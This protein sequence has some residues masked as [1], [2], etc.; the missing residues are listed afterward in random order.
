MVLSKHTDADG[1]LVRITRLHAGVSMQLNLECGP[2]S[3]ASQPPNMIAP[4]FHCVGWRVKPDATVSGW[5]HPKRTRVIL[6]L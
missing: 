6:H 5:T 4:P 2:M 3:R 1:S